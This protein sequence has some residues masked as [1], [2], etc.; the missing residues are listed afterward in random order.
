MNFHDQKSILRSRWILPEADLGSIEKMAR[1]YDLPEIIARLLVSRGISL[2]GAG[3]FLSPTLQ[4]DFPDPLSLEGMADLAESLAQA[5]IQKRKIMIFGDFDVDGAT[6]T[7]ILYKFFKHVGLASGFYIPGRL[8]EGYG[9]NTEALKQFGEQGYEI[10]ILADCGTTAFDVVKAGR[11]L[12]LEIIILDHHEPEDL[13][14]PAHHI[15][16]PKRRDDHSGLEMLAACGVCFMLAVALNANL[17]KRGYY[18]ERRIPEAPLKDWLDIVALGT[19]CDMVPLTG[20]NRLIV[21]QGFAASGKTS[22][23]GLKALMSVAKLSGPITP[24]HAGFVL[25]PRINAGS[26]IHKS[27]LGAQLLTTDDPQEAVNIA[28]TLEDCNT[29]R[30]DIQ[31]QMERAAIAQVERKGLD[32]NPLLI[33]DDRNWH[34]GL[35]GLVAGRLKERFGIPAVVITYTEGQ[36]GNLEGRGSGRSVPGIHIAQAFIEAKNEGLLEKGGGHAMAG[37]F[38]LA[39]EKLEALKSF[40]CAHIEKQKLSEETLVETQIEGFLSV[41]GLTPEFVSL[42]EDHI[43]PFGQGHPEPLFVVPHVKIQ[44]AD[45]VGESHLRLMVSDWEGGPW[46]KA[47]AFRAAGTPLGDLLLKRSGAGGVHIAGTLKKNDW[48]GQSR[49]EMHIHDALLPSEDKSM[50]AKSAAS[51]S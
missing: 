17:R 31:A 29:K 46:I 50:Q 3:S 18:K 26:R 19:V 35:S 32:Q 21:R 15:I 2:E 16:N 10:V 8:T 12:G 1:R 34:P 45:I 37:G 33:V 43:G 41:R 14:P 5:V 20:V 24:Y 6:S 38:T 25:G 36:D 40:L 48:G 7:A 4:R 30:K 23:A 22:N 27:E 28:W 42:I 47:M 51:F 49:V 9:P 11:E 13:L 39:P 44:K